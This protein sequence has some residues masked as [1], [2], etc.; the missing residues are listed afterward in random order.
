MVSL[1]DVTYDAPHVLMKVID[2]T[3]FVNMNQ[4]QSLTTYGKYCED[5]L[6]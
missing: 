3:A 6:L 2:G 5:E 4:P 1:V